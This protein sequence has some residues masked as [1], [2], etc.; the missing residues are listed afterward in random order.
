VVFL[1]AILHSFT[2]GVDTRAHPLLKI[3]MGFYAAV[4]VAGFFTRW[5]QLKSAPVP[6]KRL[7]S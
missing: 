1:I 7:Q 4:A 5:A 6:P 2:L 3:L